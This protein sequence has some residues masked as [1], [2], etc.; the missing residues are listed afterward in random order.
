MLQLT[1]PAW[2]DRGVVLSH[3]EMERRLGEKVWIE[4]MEYVRGSLAFP[5]EPRT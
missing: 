4:R 3:A 1:H 2:I 5:P